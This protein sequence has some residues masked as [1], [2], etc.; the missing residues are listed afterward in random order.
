VL[1]AWHV[2]DACVE[3]PPFGSFESWSRR[4]REPLVW[5]G[6]ADPC[7]TVAKA[8]EDDPKLSALLTIVLQWKEALGTASSFTMR[9]FTAVAENACNAPRRNLAH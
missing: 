6:R 4:V 3:L 8:R 1:R 5:L 2:A 9:E 7:T